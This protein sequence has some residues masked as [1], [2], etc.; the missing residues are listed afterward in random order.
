MNPAKHHIA[1]SLPGSEKILDFFGQVFQIVIDCS[2]PCPCDGAQF[3]HQS[4]ILA[5]IEIQSDPDNPWVPPRY[6]NNGRPGFRIA[7]VVNQDQFTRPV[8]LI[9]ERQRSVRRFP[10][11]GSAVEDGNNDTEA[12]PFPIFHGIRGP[13]QN[14]SNLLG[15]PIELGFD[16]P[17]IGNR[18]RCSATELV[19][20]MAPAVRQYRRSAGEL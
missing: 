4:G 13:F 11:Q 20:S 7:A 9:E 16:S 10:K 14:R 2:D 12:D 18:R 3:A 5:I 19:V 8:A 17:H 1:S 6:R 15:Y